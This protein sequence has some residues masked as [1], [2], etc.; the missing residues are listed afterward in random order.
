MA[1]PSESE[2]IHQHDSIAD[3][4]PDMKLYLTNRDARKWLKAKPADCIKEATRTVA[5]LLPV[6]ADNVAH[7]AGDT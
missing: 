1:E 4:D 3:N 6:V 2:Q 5:R 7:N